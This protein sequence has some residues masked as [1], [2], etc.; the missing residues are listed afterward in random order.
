MTKIS[1]EHFEAFPDGIYECRYLNISPG[2][3]SSTSDTSGTGVA[4]VAQVVQVEQVVS[5]GTGDAGSISGTGDTGGISGTGDKSGIGGTD[6]FCVTGGT[7]DT[8]DTSWEMTALGNSSVDDYASFRWQKLTNDVITSQK[9]CCVTI[10]E[11]I[12]A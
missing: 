2:N 8:S 4:Q 11:L 3:T 12:H 10:Y 9:V 7:D 5:G 1:P 6:D